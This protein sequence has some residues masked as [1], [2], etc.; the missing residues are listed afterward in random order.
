MALS[1]PCPRLRFVRGCEARPRGIVWS[2]SSSDDVDGLRRR[3]IAGLDVIADA[4]VGARAEGG[5]GW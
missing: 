4:G 2:D 5:A 3:L 1:C